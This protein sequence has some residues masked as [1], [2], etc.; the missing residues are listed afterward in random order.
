MA[1]VGLFV[2]AGATPAAL[3]L[4]ADISERFPNDRGAIM[5]LYSVF[6]AIGQIIGALIGGFAADAR[7]IDGMLIA[8]VA[9]LL[10]ALLPLAQLRRDEDELGIAPR[11][12]DA[13]GSA[14][15]TDGRPLVPVPLARGTHGAVVAPHHLATAAGLGVLRQGG[16]A[17]DAAIATNAVLAVVVPQNCGIGGD[18]FWLIW[19]AATGRQI[20][21]NGSGRAA[22]ADRRGRLRAAGHERVPFRGPLTHHGPGRGP[23]VGRRACAVRAAVARRVLAPAIE[24]AR[25]GF[26]ASRRVRRATSRR[27]RRSRG[28]ERGADAGFD[29]G[30]PPA[31][32]RMATGRTASAFRRS[33][34]RSRR[35]PATASTPSTTA[36]SATGRRAPWPRPV[37][38]ITGDD[39]RAHTS[40][41]GDPIG[42][43]YRG[44]RAT[45]HPPNSSGVVALEI[46][47][48]L[49][50]FEPPAVEAFGPAGVADARWVH[51]GLEAAQ[52]RDGRPRRA[53]STDPEARDVPVADAPRPARGSRR[54]P[55][56]RPA[57]R[58]RPAVAT[59]PPG[60]GTIFLATVDADGN[61]VSLIESNW[62]GF[63]SGVV[64]PDT[65]IHYQNRGSYFSLD[66]DHAERPRARASGR[67]TRCSPGCCSVTASPVRGSSSGRWAATPSR[68]STPSS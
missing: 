53:T 18:A 19:D 32:P 67:S 8:T 47:G 27:W 45:T 38:R 5:G 62:A 6:L 61:A 24:L 31:R 10:V 16:S 15:M 54:S 40:T 64:D 29:H 12:S 36:T 7:G 44:V 66:P 48:I 28:D 23:V 60:G 17:V 50:Q 35:W 14:G 3:G 52:A 49:A 34:R 2:L 55:P 20:A 43:D 56:D 41:W 30:L 37:R 22:A 33:R 4:L 42:I 57:A 1:A 51:L 68:R 46:L 26:P 65:G 63:G 58:R 13:V 59:N 21:L 11:P 9:L 39:L 25:D